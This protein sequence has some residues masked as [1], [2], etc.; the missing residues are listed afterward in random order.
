M[1]EV[2]SHEIVWETDN[3][4]LIFSMF[5]WYARS[6]V[7]VFANFGGS[8]GPVEWEIARS[9][10]IEAIRDDQSGEGDAQMVVSLGD[11]TFVLLL[12][13]PHGVVG[14]KT[15]AHLIVRFIEETLAEVSEDAEDL[16]AE[17]DNAISLILEEQL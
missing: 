12:Q 15:K 9:L 16:S 5:T 1:A 17:I 4:L 6:S 7:S 8:D 11:D 2:I 3:D 10:F 13:S 14:L